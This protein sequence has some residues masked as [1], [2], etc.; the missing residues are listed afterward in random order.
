MNATFI[1]DTLERL[2]GQVAWLVEREKQ[3]QELFDELTPVLREVLATA[4]GKLDALEK[5]GAF[6]LVRALGE[7][8]SHLDAAQPIGVMGM[9]RASRDDDARKG[10]GVV[11]QLLREIGKAATPAAPKAADKRERLAKMLGPKRTRALPAAPRRLPA[12][13][14]EPVAIPADWS[15]ELAEKL[16]AELGIALTPEHWK[17]ID[18]A[19][20]DF[21]R[22]KAAANIRRLTQITGLS[23][24]D[25]Y[26]LFPKAPGRTIARIAG[27]P[28]PAGCL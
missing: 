2:E 24:R 1:P 9:M 16:A 6:A 21:E 7:A 17:V 22:N 12:P 14:V 23:T 26:A 25:L 20:D 15:H 3:K 5:R 18:A 19:R 4:I 27:T 11:M 28:K 13:I 8:V 10:M